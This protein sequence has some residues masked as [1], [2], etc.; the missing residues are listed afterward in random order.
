MVAILL[1]AATSV[2]AQKTAPA[3]AAAASKAA[4]GAEQGSDL[5]AADLAAIKRPPLPPF[6]PQIPRR[7]QLANGMIIF[8]QE[9][10]ELPLID[11]TAMIRGGSKGESADKVGMISILGT[12]WRTGGTKTRTG[13]QLDDILEARAARVETGGGLN[14]VSLSLSCLK[15]DFDFVFDVFNDILRNPEF[16][17][18]KIDLAKDGIRTGIA[19]RNDNLG[20]IAGRE[21]TKIGYGPQSPYARVPEYATVKAVARQDLLDWHASHVFPN[22][23]LFGITGDFDSAEMEAK[24]RKAFDGWARGSDAK[25]PQVDVPAPRPGVYFVE[26]SDVN[27]S[28]ISMVAPGI[29]RDNPDYYALEVLNQIFG[30]SF[31]SRLFS[32]LRTREGLAYSVGGGTG[33][34]LGHPGLTRI[35]MGTKSG[36]TARAIEGLYKEIDGMHTRPVTADEMQKARDAILNSFIFEYDSKGKVMQARISFEFY[37]YPVDFL[38]QY[39]KRI[40]A[41][42]AADVDRVARKY[43]DKNKFAVL[44]VG[45][46]A[47]FDKPLNTFGPVTNIDITIPTGE[48]NSAPQ[49]SNAEGKALLARVV[50]GAGGAAKVLGIKSMRRKSTISVQGN[51]IESE[52]TDV[53]PDKIHA[54]FKLQMGEANMVVAAQDGFLEFGGNVNPLPARQRDDLLN[55]MSREFWLVAQHADDPQ[56]T[57]SA[58]GR[59][60]V[61]EVEA[62]VLD[63]N[64]GRSQVRWFVDPRT[65]HILRA[66]FQANTPTGP[67]EQVVDYSEWKAADGI[68]LPFHAEVTTNGNPGGSITVNSYEFNPVIDPKLF[69]KPETK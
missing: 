9:D 69:D 10:H 21:S 32:S 7:I 60:K 2:S 15:G 34:L 6:H 24:L 27:Q 61:G 62:S 26:K 57:F 50:E 58:Q 33:S 22:N 64:T 29:R 51:V 13:D 36:S 25:V 37:G 20:Q 41:V 55:E 47:D 46:A 11:A 30:G 39:Q 40:E 16:R 31:G 44:V 18:E 68:T 67:A 1:A 52:Q 42:T 66:R 5:A 45:Q 54:H 63:V 49:A 53:L 19:R 8:L 14:S 38:E 35:S 65:G 17:Q 3:K 56:Y 59:E 28:E 4:P 12:A 23:I 43:L 48:S